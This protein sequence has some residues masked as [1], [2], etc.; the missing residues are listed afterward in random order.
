MIVR[1]F[2]VWGLL[3]G[4]VVSAQAKNWE[5][6]KNCRLIPNKYNDGDSF[7][8]RKDGGNYT[9][10]LRL[11]FVDTAETDRG[12][13]ER[14]QDQAEYWG[15]SVDDVYKLGKEGTKFTERFLKNG[16]TVHTKKAKAMGRSEKNRYYALVEVDG[17]F[18]NDALMA[19]GLARF[20]GSQTD[21]P[22]GLPSKSRFRLRLKGSENVAKKMKKGGWGMP[23]AS[24]SSGR[25]T[26]SVPSIF[27]TTPVQAEEKDIPERMTL[28]QPVQVFS[29]AEPGKQVGTL[30][31][32]MSI[33][34]LDTS[35]SAMLR[36]RFKTKNQKIYEA[37][38]RRSDVVKQIPAL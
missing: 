26:S 7:K 4:L 1:S 28:T 30:T 6:W 19:E 10:I 33:H 3:A 23:A 9:Y 31:P 21:M 8:I 20:Y 36:V 16:F 5:E 32:G 11:Y 12:L 35:A 29:I 17:T 34:I 27:A 22:P 38:L 15:I 25:I 2:I 13:D 18:L 24:G 14:M 37:L